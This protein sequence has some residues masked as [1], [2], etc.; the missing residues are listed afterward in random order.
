MEFEGLILILLYR[1]PSVS[2]SLFIN[3]LNNLLSYS[4]SASVSKTIILGDFNVDALGPNNAQLLEIMGRYNFTSVN[5]MKTHIQGSCLDHV[6]LS[7]NLL[8]IYHACYA[9]PTYY[10]DHYYVTLQLQRSDQMK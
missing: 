3:D 4:V 2:L 9:H 8:K 10:S 6:Y 7:L 5:S 1:S